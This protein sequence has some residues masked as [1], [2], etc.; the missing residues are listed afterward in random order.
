MDLTGGPGPERLGAS[1]TEVTRDLRPDTARC[2]DAWRC[3]GLDDDPVRRH[4]HS[5]LPIAASRHTAIRPQADLLE[6]TVLQRPIDDHFDER[7]DVQ[8]VPAME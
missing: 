3:R 7:I 8:S 2:H 4:T 6:S 1:A 5:H